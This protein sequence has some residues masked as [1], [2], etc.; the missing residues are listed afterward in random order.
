MGSVSSLTLVKLQQE[1]IAAL[2]LLLKVATIVLG[3][4][5]SILFDDFKAFV[6]IGIPTFPTVA[7]TE[8]FHADAVDI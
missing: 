8:F 1:I 7:L 2:G 5:L 3:C 4:I 6:P